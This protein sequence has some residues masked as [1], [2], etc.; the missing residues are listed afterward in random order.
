MKQSIVFLSLALACAVLLMPATIADPADLAVDT[1][2]M[3]RGVVGH[4]VTSVQLDSSTTGYVIGPWI[5]QPLAPANACTEDQ[6]CQRAADAVCKA[7]GKGGAQSGTAKANQKLTG[8]D[9]AACKAK[10]TSGDDVTVVCL[11]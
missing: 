5:P 2:I 1:A 3:Y 6:K 10:C 4:V 9:A 11:D 8:S 7:A